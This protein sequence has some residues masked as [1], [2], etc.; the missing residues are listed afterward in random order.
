MELETVF[1]RGYGTVTR[2]GHG[3]FVDLAFQSAGEV[4][5]LQVLGPEFGEN[6]VDGAFHALLKSVENTHTCPFLS[7]TIL[8]FGVPRANSMGTCL[9]KFHVKG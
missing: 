7:V 8:R 9:Q 4:D 5:G 3:L 1:V 6:P 2:D